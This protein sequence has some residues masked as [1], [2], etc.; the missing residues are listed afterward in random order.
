MLSFLLKLQ[1]KFH[2]KCLLAWR[3][4]TFLNLDT[5]GGGLKQLIHTGGGGLKHHKSAGVMLCGL[6]LVL[7]C[8]H[9][10]NSSMESWG[11]HIIWIDC[12]YRKKKSTLFNLW[13]NLRQLWWW[14]RWLSLKPE[15]IFLVLHFFYIPSHS[16]QYS[17]HR[18]W[19]ESCWIENTCNNT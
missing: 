4:T 19:V 16:F 9:I 12:N 1:E 13:K 15:W 8:G 14:W 3:Q 7:A 5:S 6:L 17:M 11:V 10:I 2:R 18:L